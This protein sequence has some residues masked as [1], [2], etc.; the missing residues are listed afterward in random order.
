MGSR[1]FTDVDILK[2]GE[3]FATRVGDKADDGSAIPGE[4]GE[5]TGE[6]G[7]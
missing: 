5:G 4:F 1:D 6:C 7:G 2:V 3:W